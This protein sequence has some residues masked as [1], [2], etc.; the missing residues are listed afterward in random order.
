MPTSNDRQTFWLGKLANLNVARTAKDGIAPHKPLMLFS[1]M[2]LIEQGIIRDR[3]VPYNADLVTCFRNY[4]AHVHDRRR[5][6]PDIPMPFNALGSDRDQIWMRFDEHG[7]PSKSKLTTRLARLDADL[8]DCLLDPDFRTQARRQLIA[9]Y[10][11]P[12]EQISLYTHFGLPVP[13]SIELGVFQQD[14]EAFKARQ[15]KGRDSRFR[16]DV[17]NG[18]RYTCALTGYRL[19]STLGYLVQACHIHQHAK[20]GCDDPGNGLALTP[21][22]HWMF[23][24][25]LWTLIPKGDDLLIEVALKRFTESSPLGETLARHHGRPPHFHPNANLRPMLE[26]LEWHRAH[27]GMN[28]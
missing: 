25:G 23:D 10:F 1:V 5:T 18:Y 12:P 13:G 6:Q 3:W 26:H 16:S 7:N 28:S 2:D 11:S 9:N 19:E 4:W 22:A 27:H 20:S 21:D 17:G 24:K 14:R 8:F 15:K